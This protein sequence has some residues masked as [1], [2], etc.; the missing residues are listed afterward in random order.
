MNYPTSLPQNGYPPTP[1][2]SIA[3][4]PNS[5]GAVFPTPPTSGTGTSETREAAEA[6]RKQR[7]ES[8]NRVERR[9]R[10]NINQRIQDL[11]HL[12]P[13]H[14]LHKYNPLVANAI[15]ETSGQDTNTDKGPNKGDIL[16]GAVSWM[17]DL[18]W[19]TDLLLQTQ[20]EMFRNLGYD[21]L[22]QSED[23]RKMLDEL[24]EA[25]IVT[26]AHGFGYSRAQSDE[27]DI[28]SPTPSRPLG[29][30]EPVS[31]EQARSP[32]NIGRPRMVMGNDKYGYSTGSGG[33]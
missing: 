23:V 25:L 3:S 28:L 5:L 33:H 20:E 15:P 9:R 11:A 22:E 18:M 29:E 2:M 6:K 12:V 7:R 10:D 30:A 1:A 32:P 21:V 31:R 24:R 16:D 14:R 13:H 4:R 8:H 27:S 17:R 26:D 19:I